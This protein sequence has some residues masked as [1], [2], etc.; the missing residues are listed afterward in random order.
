MLT[1]KLRVL[2][3]DVGGKRFREDARTVTVNRHGARIRTCALHHVSQVVRLVNPVGQSEADFRVV[4]P[5]APV[6]EKGSE[7]GVECLEADQNIW[8]IKFPPLAE[9]ESAFAKGLLECRQCRTAAFL[10]LSAVEYEVLETAGILSKA[11]E[12]C[13]SVSP[14]G[15]AEKLL[16]LNSQ[17]SEA[18]LFREAQAL[19]QGGGGNQNERRYRRVALQ[20]PLL[21]R[22][23]YGQFE[24][25]RTENV[26]KS[27]FCFLSEKTYYVG[28]GI[29]V[30]CPYD[31]AGENIEVPARIARARQQAGT[32]CNIYG[33]RYETHGRHREEM[34]MVADGSRKA[35]T[36]ALGSV[37]CRT[38]R[39]FL[40][41]VRGRKYCWRA[42][43]A[44]SRKSA[45]AAS[46]RA[47]KQMPEWWDKSGKK[48]TV[49]I[50]ASPSLI[51]R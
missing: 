6:S 16:E 35:L 31:A 51:L 28:H 26:S 8:G 41:A 7:W 36:D 19:A 48:R 1:I 22:D 18:R 4:G 32:E 13:G 14:W 40:Q 34:R 23:Y 3:N 17:P 38:A 42:N 39:R 20:L 37:L 2:G 15:F 25:S 45:S 29:S 30:A 12:K 44:L 47:G 21:I 27:G 50:T 33:V 5:L 9:G 10:R 24:I 49:T 46:V 43:W 11:R